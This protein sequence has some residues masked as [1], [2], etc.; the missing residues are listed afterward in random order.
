MGPVPTIPPVSTCSTVAQ[1]PN[2][3]AHRCETLR[4]IDE[5]IQQWAEALGHLGFHGDI[6][7][8]SWAVHWN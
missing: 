5:A 7:E 8:I 4:E 2:G 6:M 3:G 1:I